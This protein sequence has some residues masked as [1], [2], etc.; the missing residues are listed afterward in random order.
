[1]GDEIRGEV[2]KNRKDIIAILILA[3]SLYYVHA[4]TPII[5]PEIAFTICI[6]LLVVMIFS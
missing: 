1:M 3:I 4:R 5:S 6:I 2:M